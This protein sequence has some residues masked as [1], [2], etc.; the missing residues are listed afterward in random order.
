MIVLSQSFEVNFKQDN[1]VEVE[2]RMIKVLPKD[3]LL[4]TK[5]LD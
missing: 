2:N 5:L 3:W 1:V 4:S